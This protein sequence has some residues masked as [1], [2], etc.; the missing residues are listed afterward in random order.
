MYV[1]PTA[2]SGALALPSTQDCDERIV[3]LQNEFPKRQVREIKG[4]L[5]VAEW[6]L[7]K[8][9]KLLMS[10]AEQEKAGGAIG[11]GKGGK[12]KGSGGGKSSKGGGKEG[13]KAATARPGGEVYRRV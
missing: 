10:A 7:P 2:A 1:T 13:V 9:R 3:L 4:A 6:D 5:E 11:D 12:K 8:A